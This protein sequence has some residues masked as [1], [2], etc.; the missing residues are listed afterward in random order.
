LRRT[1][2]RRAVI[3]DANAAAGYAATILAETSLTAY[4]PLDELT[5]T[6]AA[7]RKGTKTLTDVN[8]PDLSVAG[9][10]DEARTGVR[11]DAAASQ[12]A[13]A[14]TSTLSATNNYALE[15]WLRLDANPGGTA[16]IIQNGTDAAGYAIAVNS[17]GQLGALT[18]A[19]FQS[20]GVTLVTGTW[21][22]VVLTR[23]AGTS[24]LYLDGAQAGS[25]WTTAPSTPGANTSIGRTSG[26][27]YL[28]GVVDE[29]A[30]YNG[31]LTLSQVQAHSA[32]G[33]STSATTNLATRS[34]SDELG[35]ETDVWRP[36]GQSTGTALVRDN[37]VYDR[38]GHLTS[39][40]ANHVNGSPSG[41]FGDDDLTISLASNVLGELTGLC[42]GRQ[43]QVGGCDPTTVPRTRPGT[44]PMT[45]W[46]AR[47]PRSH[48]SIRPP[49][50]STHRP[51]S[52]RRAAVST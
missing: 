29:V 41:E 27:V 26:G 9:A 17:A 1:R 50:P 2:I 19:T 39:S 11:L 52:T 31:A 38:L 4:W 5:G 33:R 12:A 46:V 47:S 49:W 15:A 35:R 7:D 18:N 21:H 8:S 13:T 37:R 30:A 14:T 44:G 23:N 25:T 10:I 22:H 51:R 16:A 42:P 36:F 40:I 3:V 43:N 48:R 34:R 28:S 20:S 24:S 32:A 6:S 45:P